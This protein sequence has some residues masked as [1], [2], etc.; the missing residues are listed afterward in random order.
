MSG[1][2]PPRSFWRDN[3]L[4][5]VFGALLIYITWMI[6]DPVSQWLFNLIS[7]WSTDAGWGAIPEITSA[8]AARARMTSGSRRAVA[9]AAEVAGMNAS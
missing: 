6:S 8:T 4:S 2:P 7:T 3:S 5:L 9:G 1:A